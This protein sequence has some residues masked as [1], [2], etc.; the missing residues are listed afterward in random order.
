MRPAQDPDNE[1][2]LALMRRWMDAQ[3]ARALRLRGTDWFAWATGGA[4]SAVLLTAETGIAEVLVTQEDAFILTDDIEARRL[5]DEEVSNAWGWHICPWDDPDVREQFVR[6]QAGGGAVVSDRPQKGEQPLAP[7]A[8]VDRLVLTDAELD[9]YRRLGRL[10]GEA[11]TEVL[12]A[13]HPDWTEY[14]LAG[15]G[16]RALWARGIHPALVLA[17]GLDRMTRYRHPTP[18]GEKL[19]NGAM[20][21]FCAR[22]H[23]LYANVTRFVRFTGA[24]DLPRQQAIFDIEAAGLAACL[25]GRPAVGVYNALKDAY[26][27]AG[28]GDALRE[29]HQGG[30]TGYLAREYV[31]T[32]ET[33][34]VLRE[35]MAVAFNPSLT[36][37]KIEDT[38]VIGRDGLE[39]LTFDPAW[40]HIEM[41]GRLRPLWLEVS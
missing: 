15:A 1:S 5:A 30:V 7:Q 10:A 17:A 27:A 26:A 32:P 41:H 19:V 20:L 2:K 3:G 21:V 23:G 6:Q 12:H 13:A 39:N 35:N 9:R 25:P 29:H 34:I 36:G 22:Q 18:S 40:P 33:S 28:H 38:F 8:Q 37:M 14:E 4:S 24:P 11:M 31:V 16:A